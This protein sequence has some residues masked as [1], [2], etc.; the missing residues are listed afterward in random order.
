M[1]VI[2]WL[3]QCFRTTACKTVLTGKACIWKHLYT[4]HQ[5]IFSPNF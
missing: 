3:I 5:T 2:L 1:M 4:N